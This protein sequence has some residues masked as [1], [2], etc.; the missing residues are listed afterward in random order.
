MKYDILKEIPITKIE[1]DK[2]NR[3]KYVKKLASKICNYKNEESLVIGL[4]GE[5]GS[6]KTSML[7]MIITMINKNPN[8]NFILI[9]FN[10][11]YFSNQNELLSEFFN[12]IIIELSKNKNITDKIKNKELINSIIKYSS[13]LINNISSKFSIKEK[14][15]IK[16]FIKMIPRL[17]K[18]VNNAVEIYNSLD[19]NLID[20]KENIN[21]YIKKNNIKILFII[22]DID[23]L[24]DIE[25]EQIFKLVKLVADF[26][27][28][29]YL[30]AYDK[31]IVSK[32]LDKTQHDKGY[33][34]L[35]KIVQ[36]PLDIPK[37]NVEDLKFILF[38]ELKQIIP[39]LNEQEF[40]N[41]YYKGL[42]KFF[43]NIRDIIRYCNLLNFNLDN[44]V[45]EVNHD[46]FMKITALQLFAPE[47]FHEIYNKKKSIFKLENKTIEEKK[48]LID[49]I[50]TSIKKPE[51]KKPVS[52]IM[53]S[54]FPQFDKVVYGGE[55]HRGWEADLNICNSR[56]FDKYFEL[57]VRDGNI[58][59]V[60]FKEI[61]SSRIDESK[62]K[63][64]IININE[65]GKIE[66]F[67][68]KLLNYSE[69]DLSTFTNTE[70]QNIISS[71]FDIGDKI[72]KGEGF[73]TL[74]NY[75]KI[76]DIVDNLLKNVEDKEIR[77]EILKYSMENS[78]NSIWI[79]LHYI[80]RKN[81]KE[82]EIIDNSH[83]QELKNI[84]IKKLDK[85]AK[86]KKL[87]EN[88]NLAYIIQFWKDLA[89]KKANGFVKKL[90]STDEGLITFLTAFLK[91][92]YTYNFSDGS[93]KTNVELNKD[94][95]NYIDKKDIKKRIN[96]LLN[97]PKTENKLEIFLKEIIN[98]LEDENQ[99]E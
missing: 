9:N 88:Q 95:Y 62:F 36:I 27:N 39:K 93:Q 47:A 7:E 91:E 84:V 6:G 16:N 42:N 79:Y 5:W 24:S 99:Y 89:P 76:K 37:I 46:D 80:W 67:L 8:N 73:L 75:V 90:I 45:N 31:K 83:I 61:I 4:S 92:S 86:E 14:K 63:S 72:E 20:L 38:N 13:Y 64:K 77:F 48:Q 19:E 96:K 3:V 60:E 57:V 87:E 53:S 1:N 29:I 33:E 68:N 56:H 81:R 35:E 44:I 54:L 94:I 78:Q 2:L 55:F 30:L 49:I 52:S 32:S 58:S 98:K 12:T 70:I 28:T 69:K 22:D 97:N 41:S 25:T 65:E 51:L 50:T 10:P 66:L 71:L 85:F 82:S 11:W 43:N 34:Y 40:I 74:P 18:D 15:G 59:N 17:H 21:N 26:K 23:R